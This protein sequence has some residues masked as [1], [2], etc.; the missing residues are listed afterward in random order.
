MSNSNQGADLQAQQPQPS[1]NLA[2][3][4]RFLKNAIPISGA[5]DLTHPKTHPLFWYDDTK[6]RL[7]ICTSGVL[8]RLFSQDE[9]QKTFNSQSENRFLQD[10]QLPGF[11]T[12]CRLGGQLSPGNEKKLPPAVDSLQSVILHELE[13]SLPPDIPLSYFL[14]DDVVRQFQYLAKQVNATFDT[15]IGQTTLLPLAFADST[16]STPNSGKR[17]AKIISAIER[18]D[19]GN[20]FERMVKAIE[21]ELQE[22][23]ELDEDEIED[24]LASLEDEYNSSES[25]LQRFLSFLDDEALSRVRLHITFQIMDAIAEKAKTIS[26]RNEQR[27]VEYVHRINYFVEFVKEEGLNLN[28]KQDYGEKAEFNF[29]DFIH[30]DKFFSCLAVWPE[31]KTQIFEDRKQPSDSTNYEV[32]REISY[33]FRV[34]GQNPELGKPAFEARLE[35]IKDCLFPSDSE[36][37]LSLSPYLMNWSIAELVFLGVVVPSG[38]R[39]FSKEQLWETIRQFIQSI[40]ANPKPQL[41]KLY[42][43]LLKRADTMNFIATALLKILRSQG[44]KIIAQVERNTSQQ[45]ICIKKDIVEWERLKGAESGTKNLLKASSNQTHEK[46]IWLGEMEVDP[47]PISVPN[48]LFSIK[49]STQ[50]SEQDLIIKDSGKQLKF[51]RCLPQQVLQILFVPYETVKTAQSS[52]YRCCDITKYAKDWIFHKAVQVEYETD[53]L[54]LRANNENNDNNKQLHAAAVTVF[55][56]LVY[57]CLWCIIN[58]LQQQNK[59]EN[60][61]FVT[62]ILRLQERREND[63]KSGEAYIYAAA[64]AI[65]SMLAQDNPTRMQGIVLENLQRNRYVQKGVYNALFSVFPLQL[66]TPQKPIVPKI[67]L[68]SYIARPCDDNPYSFQKNHILISQSYIAT[69]IESPFSGYEMKTARMQSDLAYSDR[70]LQEQRLIREE[71]AYLQCQGCEHIIL[72]SHAY[73]SRRVN[74]TVD[75]NTPLTS[76]KF[77]EKLSENYPD[78]TFYTLFRDVFP[79]TRLHKRGYKESGFEITRASDHT[80]F[81]TALVEEMGLRD[82]IPIYTFAT[83]HA[84][85]PKSIHQVQQERPQSGFCVYFLLSDSRIG[86]LD[87]RERSRQ[88]LINPEQSSPVHPCLL[89]VLRG[90]HFI[91]SEQGK[92]NGQYLPVLDPFGWIS[93]NTVEAAGEVQIMHARRKGKALLSYPAILT[94]IAQILRRRA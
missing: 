77:L 41:E 39:K 76:R 8:R 92:R 49:V 19:T 51:K 80:H 32:I 11:G 9:F 6:R 1:V 61:S 81:L 90:L 5:S 2:P 94:H 38:D 45:Y 44:T 58:Q 17:V 26:E 33:R 62:S 78:L 87:W 30:K 13:T 4:V 55:S 18:I 50:V 21:D 12:S 60:S 34:N 20:Y 73:G 83:L 88:H 48:L 53:V 25:Q 29:L 37:D 84:V 40:E 35:R 75:Y 3:L 52:E 7:K 43:N 22:E 85:E 10:F 65:E 71:V 42:Q 67:G 86:T 79:G 57:S 28:L 36:A 74:K 16:I 24:A 89:S 82:V 91:E 66:E 23:G 15:G 46:A 47:N 70:D 69:P 59:A 93:P 72:L 68:I 14:L 54:K 27:L 64:Q 31:W 56:V 63:N